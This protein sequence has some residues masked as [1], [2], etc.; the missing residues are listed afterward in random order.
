VDFLTFF[1]FLRFFLRLFKKTAR[2]FLKMSVY[3]S[4]KTIFYGNLTK[5][6]GFYRRIKAFAGEKF[7]SNHCFFNK[8][9]I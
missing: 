7:F 3:T 2:S 1:Y 6:T 5:S 9:S 4:D 8:N